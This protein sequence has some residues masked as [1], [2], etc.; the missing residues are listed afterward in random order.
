MKKMYHP[1][2]VRLIEIIDDPNHH[3]QYLIQ[4]FIP[5]GDLLEKIKQYDKNPLSEQNLRKYFRQLMT[6]VWY[7]HEIVNIFHRDI[8]PDNILID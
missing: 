8:K 2:I 7:C 3:K 1:H 6:A 4:E 5:N